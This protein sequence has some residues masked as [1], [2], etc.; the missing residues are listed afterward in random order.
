MGAAG[1][2]TALIGRE[3]GS[4]LCFHGGIDSVNVLALGNEEDVRKEDAR[5][6]PGGEDTRICR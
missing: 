4:R 5:G 1:M 2:D 3:F 6:C